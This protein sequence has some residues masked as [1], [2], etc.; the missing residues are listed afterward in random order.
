MITNAKNKVVKKVK[1]KAEEPELG[2]EVQCPNCGR[3]NFS[4]VSRCGRC[5]RVSC[6]RCDASQGTCKCKVKKDGS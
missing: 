2:N 6:D 4:Q 5:G 1:K 3:T